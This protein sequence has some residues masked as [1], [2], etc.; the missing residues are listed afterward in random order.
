[1][2]N[3]TALNEPLGIVCANSS[4]ICKGFLVDLSPCN[5]AFF[6]GILLVSSLLVLLYALVFP[7]QKRFT[8]RKESRR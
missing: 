2:V 5:M 8:S 1:M 3:L 7:N 4:Y 6:A